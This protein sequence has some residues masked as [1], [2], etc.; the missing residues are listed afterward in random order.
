VLFEVQQHEFHCSECIYCKT[1]GSNIMVIA[2]N[3]VGVWTKP[4]GC[5][6]CLVLGTRVMMSLRR[7]QAPTQLRI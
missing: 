1:A 4:P 3:V 7:K 5:F 6:W 2:N